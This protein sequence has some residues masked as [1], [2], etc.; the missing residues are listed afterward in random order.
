MSFS[1]AATGDKPADPYTD[2]NKDEVDMRQKIDDLEKFIQECKFAMMTTRSAGSSRLASRGMALAGTEKGGADLI[3][4][5]NT[6]SGKTDD[7]ANDPDVNISFINA[8]GDWASISGH[9]TVITDRELVKKYYTSKLK[10]W[11]GDLKDG[12]HDGSENDPRIGVIR[13]EAETASYA[14]SKMGHLRQSAEMAKAKAT[15][16][17]ANINK[18]RYISE[19]EY[20]GWRAHE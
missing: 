16:S 19:K 5:T 12:T 7:I 10:A 17:A 1:N 15:G 20:T 11:L 9:A 8:D 18:L 13:V 2:K 6:E 3:F 4:Q 14:L